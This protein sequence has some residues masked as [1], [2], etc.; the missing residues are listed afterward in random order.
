MKSLSRGN[1]VGVDVNTASPA[2][3][4]YVSGLNQLSEDLL[5]STGTWIVP[6]KRAVSTG[7]RVRRSDLCSVR[8][9]PEINTAANALD[10]T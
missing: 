4:K 9:L 1:Y 7:C 3:L 6:I 8:R 5:I 2:L 10:A